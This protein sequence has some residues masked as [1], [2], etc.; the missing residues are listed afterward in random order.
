MANPPAY[1]PPKDMFSLPPSGI[2]PQS[3]RKRVLWWHDSV[4]DI[5][6]SNPGWTIKQIAAHMKR[7]EH[8]LYLVTNSDV[9]RARLAARR[10]EH[11][12]NLS[13]SIIEKTGRVADAALELVANRL[14]SESAAAIPT[15]QLF[16]LADKALERLGYG[17]KP[18]AGPSVVVNN[19]NGTQQNAYMPVPSDVIR[20]SQQRIRDE[21][22]ARA[23]AT[24]QALPPSPAENGASPGDSVPVLDLVANPEDKAA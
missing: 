20:E 4:I 9:F 21:Q 17:A 5:M 7:K 11:A 18:Q 19:V 22:A 23:A 8:T 3:Q 14:A 12:Q 6:L 15:L 1:S 2:A 16:S 24:P 13:T 10:R